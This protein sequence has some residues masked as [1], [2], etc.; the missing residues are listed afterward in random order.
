MAEKQFSIRFEVTSNILGPENGEEDEIRVFT[1]VIRREQHGIAYEPDQRHV[2]ITLREVDLNRANP[3]NSQELAKR[4]WQ[5]V[6]HQ[7][8]LE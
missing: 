5:P 1:R 3:A 7:T 4:C 8:C 6:R 2:D